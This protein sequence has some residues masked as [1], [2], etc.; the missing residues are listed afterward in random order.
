MLPGSILVYS[1][2]RWGGE[3][4]LGPRQGEGSV[5]FHHGIGLL[6]HKIVTSPVDIHIRLKT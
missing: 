6:H 2:M 3:D 4:D 5:L 1:F